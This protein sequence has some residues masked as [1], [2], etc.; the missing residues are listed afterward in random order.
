MDFEEYL[1]QKKI[2]AKR[3]KSD[4]PE[5]WQEWAQLFMQLHPESFTMQKKFLINALRREYPLQPT[6]SKEQTS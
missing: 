4:E 6:P 5:L 1:S 3:F 2:D